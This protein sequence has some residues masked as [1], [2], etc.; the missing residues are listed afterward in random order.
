M[1]ACVEETIRAWGRLDVV[2]NNAGLMLF[3]PLEQL[4]RQDWIRVLEVDLLGAFF[5]TKQ[6]FLHMQGRGAIVNVSSVHAVE[7]TA[8]VAPYAAAKSA[9]LSLTRSAAIEGKPKRIRSN[10]IL[11]GAVETPML[12]LNPEPKPSLVVQPR[13][14]TLSTNRLQNHGQWP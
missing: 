5:F 10:A 9:R 14:P 6:A 3:K 4:E 7:T 1:K 12:R 13:S 2:M 8:Q 11:P